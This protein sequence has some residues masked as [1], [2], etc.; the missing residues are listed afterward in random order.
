MGCDGNLVVK[1]NNLYHCNALMVDFR[2]L[3][4][5]QNQRS[6]LCYTYSSTTLTC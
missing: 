4:Y 1:N 3:Y 5:R 2:I 6:Y